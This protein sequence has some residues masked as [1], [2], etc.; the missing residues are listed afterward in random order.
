LKLITLQIP[1]K[2]AETHARIKNHE[3]YE[4]HEKRLLVAP[5]FDPIAFINLVD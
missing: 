3:T 5:V 1:S 4:R 2:T